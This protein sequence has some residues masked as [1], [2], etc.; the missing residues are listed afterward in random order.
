[1]P[2]NQG[3]LD[4]ALRDRRTAV[5][6]HG[7]AERPRSIPGDQGGL[8]VQYVREPKRLPHSKPPNFTTTTKEAIAM[9]DLRMVA[10]DRGNLQL[11]MRSRND[12][13]SRHGRFY[14]GDW[15]PWQSVPIVHDPTQLVDRVEIFDA[16]S[17]GA[18][19]DVGLTGKQFAEILNGLEETRAMHLKNAQ[20]ADSNSERYQDHQQGMAD[21]ISKFLEAFKAKLGQQA[22]ESTDDEFDPDL[23]Y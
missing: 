13:I 7:D 8:R 14:R 6:K 10:D 5:G 4:K 16:K 21:G 15:N 3:S 17:S 9:I 22:D 18:K 1:M 20:R 19:P 11:Q 2:E 23:H 12:T